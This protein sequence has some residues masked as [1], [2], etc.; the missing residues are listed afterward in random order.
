MSTEDS[1]DFNKLFPEDFCISTI[2]ELN[3]WTS[4]QTIASAARIIENRC[5]ED[6][7]P[8]SLLIMPIDE[9]LNFEWVFTKVLVWLIKGYKPPKNKVDFSRVLDVEIKDET[10][11][12]IKNLR[13][14]PK[15]ASQSC[16]ESNGDVKKYFLIQDKAEV[17]ELVSFPLRA[18]MD[19]L[20]M[21]FDA[22]WGGYQIRKESHKRTGSSPTIYHTPYADSRLFSVIEALCFAALGMEI[23]VNFGREKMQIVN[24]YRSV[25]IQ[26][27]PPFNKELINSALQLSKGIKI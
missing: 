18:L 22:A 9:R 27:K 26:A 8:Q 24:N 11:K 1:N 20:F 7:D 19:V 4:V 5:I 21:G 12:K 10:I 16:Q 13:F 23:T 17:I 14:N 6:D 2:A 15:I 25:N 3:S